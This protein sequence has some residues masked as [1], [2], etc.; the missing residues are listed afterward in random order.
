[1][2]HKNNANGVER[3]PITSMLMS[4]VGSF[5]ARYDVLTK[6]KLRL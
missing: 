5:F 3:K 6:L 1:M 4:S 2:V